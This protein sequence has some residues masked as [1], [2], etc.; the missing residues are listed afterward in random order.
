VAGELL[1]M[2]GR[3]AGIAP[4]LPRVPLTTVD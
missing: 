1:L 3:D 4:M 2:H